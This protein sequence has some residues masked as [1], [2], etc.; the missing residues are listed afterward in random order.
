MINGE[1]VRILV[2]KL[3]ARVFDYLVEEFPDL[4][5]METWKTEYVNFIPEY[6]AYDY[7]KEQG[8]ND[9]EEFEDHFFVTEFEEGLLILE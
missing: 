7:A 6:S 1:T 2:D 3:P 4:L 9:V 8:Y 5:E